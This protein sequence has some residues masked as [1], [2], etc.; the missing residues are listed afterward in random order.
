KPY[1]TDTIAIRVSYA[2]GKELLGMLQ[3]GSDTIKTSSV[4]LDYFKGLRLGSNNTNSIVLNCVDSVKLFL[5]YRKNDIY[6]TSL[7]VDF[8]ISNTAHH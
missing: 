5:N 3:R 4:F 2:L 6:T 7:K 8:N 1:S